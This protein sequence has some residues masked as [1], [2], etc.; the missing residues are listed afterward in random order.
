M[1]K[2]HSSS[3]VSRRQLLIGGASLLGYFTFTGPTR[4]WA[5]AFEGTPLHQRFMQLSKLLI[6][7]ELHEGTGLRIA[8]FAAQKYARLDERI[9]QIVAVAEQHNAVEVEQFFEAIPDGEPR[10]FA[11]WVIAAWYSGASSSAA[12]AEQFTFEHALT[13]QTTLDIVPIPTY[14]YSAPNAWSRSP[15]PLLPVPSF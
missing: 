8:A 13:Y 3:G 10:D 4:A 5:Q 9:D 1:Q 7:H 2:R 15:A 6:N 14:A 11:Y 12:D